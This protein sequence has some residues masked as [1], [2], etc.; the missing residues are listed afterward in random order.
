M[1]ISTTGLLHVVCAPVDAGGGV[2]MQAAAR[3]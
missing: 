1:E 3:R 2:D